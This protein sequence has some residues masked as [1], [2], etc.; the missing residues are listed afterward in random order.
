MHGAVAEK[1][2][3][4]VSEVTLNLA[5]AAKPLR[6]CQALLERIQDIGGERTGFAGRFL[7]GQEGGQP[8]RFI[9]RQ[10]GC[11]R[12]AMDGQELGKREPGS[13]LAPSKQIEG[14]EPHPQQRIWFG[15]H[16]L[17]EVLGAFRDRGERFVHPLSLPA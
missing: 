15:P 10:P 11:H 14:M 1:E 3:V 8:T 6:L 2:A 4:G 5:I 9:E 7:D 17:L 12:M 13:D 16:L